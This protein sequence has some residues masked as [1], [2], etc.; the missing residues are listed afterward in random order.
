M[1]MDEG[2]REGMTMNLFRDQAGT[3]KAASDQVT[4][5]LPDLK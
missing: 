1:G 3:D 4:S 5:A 2:G